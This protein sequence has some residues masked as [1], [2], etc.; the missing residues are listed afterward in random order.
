[1]KT[2]KIK[3]TIQVGGTKVEL[4]G[5]FQRL[6]MTKEEKAK[7]VTKMVNRALKMLGEDE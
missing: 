1:M 6:G 4:M 2:M 3:A 5:E 7:Q